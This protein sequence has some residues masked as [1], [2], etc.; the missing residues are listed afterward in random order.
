MFVCL[1]GCCLETY[2]GSLVWPM[3]FVLLSSVCLSDGL[4]SGNVQW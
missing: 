2:N 1:A 4:M 3:M